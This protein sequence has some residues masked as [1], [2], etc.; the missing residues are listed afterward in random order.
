MHST[1]CLASR[2]RRLAV[3][4]QLRALS[5]GVL[6]VAA[7]DV[8]AT[9]R[10][11][12]RGAFFSALAGLPVRL[13]FFSYQ[14]FTF[15]RLRSCPSSTLHLF[16]MP[17]DWTAERERLMLLMAIQEANVKPTKQL[18]STVAANLGGGLTPSAVRCDPVNGIGAIKF[19]IINPLLQHLVLLSSFALPLVY[20]KKFKSDL[21]Q[22]EVLEVEEPVRQTSRPRRIGFIHST[23]AQARQQQDP[24]VP[25]LR[26]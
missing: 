10:G 20:S 4:E 18:W 12:E 25:R 13:L 8:T 17:F 23:E 14:P 6:E 9:A 1:L 26:S 22:S 21:T 3:P 16:S 11:G 19:L 24:Q 5:L 15:H 2:A 7:S